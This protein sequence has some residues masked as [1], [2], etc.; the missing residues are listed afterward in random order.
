VG[1]AVALALVA[2]A[3][4]VTTSDGPTGLAESRPMRAAEA[5]MAVLLLLGVERRRE[6]ATS[7]RERLA[8]L[9]IAVLGVG[10][11][12]V[13]ISFAIDP[14]AGGRLYGAFPTNVLQMAVAPLAVGGLLVLGKPV[15]QR[16]QALRLVTDGAAIACSTIVLG[17]YVAVRPLRDAALGADLTATSAMAYLVLDAVAFALGLLVLSRS[18]YGLRRTVAFAV[19]GLA[20][21]LFADV[22]R[23]VHYLPGPQ[24]SSALSEVGWIAALACLAIAAWLPRR[25]LSVGRDVVA[26][27]W[28][29]WLTMPYTFL[30]PVA[31]VLVVS[32][33]RGDTDEPMVIGAAAIIIVLG[34]RHVFAVREN[35]ELNGRLRASV[36][37]LA[38]RAEHDELTGLLNRSGLIERLDRLR[39]ESTVGEGQPL[40]LLFI[41]VDRFKGIND[42][43]G[44]AVGDAVL[45]RIGTRLETLVRGTDG[46]AARFAGDEFV[47]LFP[48]L[49][50]ETAALELAQDAL[51][52]VERPITLTDGG[53]V[54]VTAS[55]G[56]AI[57]PRLLD[58]ETIVREADLA[59]FEA[60]SGGRARVQLFEEDLR[61]R[62]EDRMK[63]EQ[64]LR[65]ALQT[66]SSSFEVHL[67]PLVL[68]GEDRLW[69]AEA[70]VRWRHPEHG[71][72][73]PGR[74]L[75]VAEESGMIIP[76]GEH[77][78]A[79]ACAAAV[80][81]PGL[82]VSV[83]LSPRQIHDP[84]LVATVREQLELQ[85]LA[86]G[87]LCL[88]VTE[89]V[90][91]DNRTIAVLEDLQ[92]LGV[93]VA[94][95]DFG[96]GA[97]SL[98]QL[99]RIPGAIVKIDRSFTERLDGEQGGDD[100]VMV[101]ALVSIAHQLDL[102]VVAEGIERQAQLEIVRELGVTIGQ[103]WHLGIPQRSAAFVTERGGRPLVRRTRR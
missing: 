35:E 20:L 45:H 80:A 93:R 58:G 16:T 15:R 92:A 12:L 64:E 59:M 27:G 18:A 82:I 55:A 95:D 87:R 63:I 77:I 83:N 46:L 1:A 81:V 42:T 41:D 61:A 40:A 6:E 99:R 43:L 86:P 56:V 25:R 49:D 94:I 21:L 97:S 57:S 66:R 51:D 33:R 84:Q 37:Q 28:P 44:H 13:L 72:I 48:G 29:W 30:I 26:E 60:K 98:R 68:L 76:L 52:H 39:E 24:S 75:P 31:A 78:L 88:E 5:A 96:I 32:A 19:V 79:E 89:D 10:V 85:G 34:F 23:V 102:E 14:S 103:G 36:L 91:V 3:F 73:L 4:A 17:W 69:G 54:V 22:A 74:F 9:A 101:K 71:M 8:W 2:G 90:L 50:D 7:P 100:A 70:L 62:S 65:R 11:C 53:E 67:Q 38:Y 47:L